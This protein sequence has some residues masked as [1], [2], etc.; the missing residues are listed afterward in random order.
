MKI[1]SLLLSILLV[2]AFSN[3][4]YASS[5][6]SP[7]VGSWEFNVTGAP[8]EYSRGL[9]I[10]EPGEDGELSGKVEFSTGRV[11]QIA[12][13][14]VEDESVVFEVVVDGYDVKSDLQLSGDD[15][16]GVVQTIEGNMNFSAKRAVSE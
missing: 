13:I 10:V 12:S 5:E 1:R 8:W 16:Q 4:S 2:V 11:V 7:L 9:I 15:L 3:L 14:L 6:E